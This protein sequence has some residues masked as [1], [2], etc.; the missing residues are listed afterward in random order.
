MSKNL[1][2]SFILYFVLTA[3]IVAWNTLYAYFNGVAINFVGVVGLTFV[4]LLLIFMDKD[5]IK[6]TKDLF[7]IA[8]IFCFLEF[9]VYFIFEFNIGNFDTF[10]NTIGYQSVLSLLG[11]IYFVY[12]A[13]RFVLELKNIRIKFIE[14]MLGNEKFSTKPK[15]AKE[16]TNGSLEEKPN[17]KIEETENKSTEQESLNQNTIEDVDTEIIVTEDEE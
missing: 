1:K 16:V 4:L 14:V 11:F 9:F 3:I 15:K 13:F 12:T 8:C 10:E 7:I 5:L 6:R 17:Q 2:L